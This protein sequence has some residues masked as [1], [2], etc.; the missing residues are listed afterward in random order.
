AL[1]VF[2]LAGT[3]A[4]PGPLARLS[5]K[6][7]ADGWILL[8][9]GRTT[10]GWTSPNDSQWSIVEGM[11]APQAG[12]PGLLVTTTAWADY[13]LSLEYRPRGD[14]RLGLLIACDAQGKQPG[15]GGPENLL[16]RG[17]G[18]WK[19]DLRVLGGGVISERYTQVGG[20]IGLGKKTAV[21]EAPPRRS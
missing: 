9:D 2:P 6:E 12:K 1:L 18:W 4:E 15:G 5:K 21:A 10:F 14:G 13:D 7:I 8:F 17:S 11:L 16:S 19:L 3:A 20:M